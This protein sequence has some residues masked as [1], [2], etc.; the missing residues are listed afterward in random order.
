[1]H[2]K[3]SKGKLHAL[4]SAE[5]EYLLPAGSVAITDEEAAAITA[6]Q[7]AP[8]PEQI[9]AAFVS[10]IQARLDSFARQ[11]GYDDILSACTYA[12]STITKFKNEGQTCVN[13]RDATWEAAYNIL[14]AVQTGAIPMPSSI[15]DIEADLPTLAWPA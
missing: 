12:T 5:F 8:T 15:A 9:Q 14:G 11:R 3:D 2:Y 4:D 6:A 1:M 13:L 7:N 10:A